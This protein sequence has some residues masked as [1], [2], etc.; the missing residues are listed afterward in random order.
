MIVTGRGIRQC[1]FAV[2]LIAP[3]STRLLNDQEQN[4]EAIRRSCMKMR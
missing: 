3:T 2:A 1:Q 4:Q